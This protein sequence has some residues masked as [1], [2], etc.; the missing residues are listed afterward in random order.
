M[1]FIPMLSSDTCFTDAIGTKES[2]LAVE[3][4]IGGG[5]RHAPSNNNHHHYC[6]DEQWYL[7][8]KVG[9]TMGGTFTNHVSFQYVSRLSFPRPGKMSTQSTI[10][11]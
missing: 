6:H 9:T 11:L 10:L 2:I 4:S 3:Y 1:P 5:G 8:S 7:L